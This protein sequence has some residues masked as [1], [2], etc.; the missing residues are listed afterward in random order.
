MRELLDI[1]SYRRP[2]GSHTLREMAAAHVLPLGAVADGY[3]N[4]VLDIGETPSI[5]W[6]AHLDTVH[7]KPGRQRI[8]ATDKKIMTLPGR[9]GFLPNCLGADDGVGVW[10]LCEM[11]RAGI[12]GRY[13]WHQNEEHGGH[14]SSYIARDGEALKGISIAM[15]FDRRGT[16]DVITHQ[17]GGRTASDTFAASFAAALAKAGIGDYRAEHGI[18]TDTANYADA[19][20]ECSNLSCGYSDEH[21]SNE[22]VDVRHLLRLRDALCTLNVTGLEISRKPGEDDYHV[23]R[24]D[25]DYASRLGTSGG[26]RIWERDERGIWS[27]R[28][29]AD[30]P[31]DLLPFDT[32]RVWQVEPLTNI[33]HCLR[34]DHD[35]TGKTLCGELVDTGDYW[36]VEDSWAPEEFCA[37]CLDIETEEYEDWERIN[38]LSR[39]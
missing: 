13:I 36:C 31:L 12:E 22:S 25:Y 9:K 15:A 24:W 26:N 34:Y 35:Q 10:L 39:D 38:G 37:S 3:G 17:F 4:L 32:T 20:P 6:S 21:R 8:Y 5:I 28:E 19:L 14:G 2:D 30:V 7:S 23:S 16:K 1:L 11:I 27:S 33:C 18:F 29:L